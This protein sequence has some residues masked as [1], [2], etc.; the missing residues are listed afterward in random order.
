MKK[1]KVKVDG[2]EYE[3]ELEKQ[4]GVW[5]VTIEGKSFNIE[6]EGSSVGDTSVSKRKKTSRG[7]KSG[8]ISSTIPGKVISISA[9]E[10]QMVSEGDVVMI[11]E[12]MKMQNEIQA[13]LSGMVTAINCK[14]GESVEANSPLII[15]QPEEHKTE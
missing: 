4:N 5:N 1:R 11:L 8:T 13:P 3:V 12:A 14:P 15:I 10:G 6:I 7:K 9:K 2:E